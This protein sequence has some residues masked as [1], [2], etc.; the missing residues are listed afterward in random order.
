MAIK[1]WSRGRGEASRL[2]NLKITTEFF[3]PDYDIVVEDLTRNETRLLKV[4]SLLPKT[5]EKASF[6]ARID[7]G[8]PDKRKGP[9]LDIDI[10]GVSSSIIRDFEACRNGYS[11]HHNDRSP[12]RTERIF[13]VEIT[14]PG[15]H[16]FKGTVFFN[17]TFSVA[18][19]ATASA[20]VTTDAVVIRAAR[21]LKCLVKIGGLIKRGGF[22]V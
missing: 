11:G 12:S 13:E 14:T 7:D 17:V 18:V 5:P 9:N 6:H 20:H 16:I 22:N 8:S 2:S 10:S 21:L 19:N 1:D 3:H 15:G 4:F